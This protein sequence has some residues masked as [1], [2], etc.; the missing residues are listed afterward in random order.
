MSISLFVDKSKQ[1]SWEEIET[2]LGSRLDLWNAMI[3]RLRGHYATAEDLAF[4]YGMK[5][6]WAL[7][8]RVKNKLLIN[9]YPAKEHFI[10][11][12]NLPAAMESRALQA[13]L[14]EN[15][16]AA[17]NRAHPY[18]EGRWLFVSVASQKD[19]DDTCLLLALRAEA[20]GL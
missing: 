10:A 20:L 15:A 2:A 17:I 1:P 7:R 8:F 11:Q 13:N 19:M 6:G 3:T 5:Y 12:V 4:L 16:L 18:P 9:I 14:G